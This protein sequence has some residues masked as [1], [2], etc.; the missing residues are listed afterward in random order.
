M[1]EYIPPLVTND[2]DEYESLPTSSVATHMMSGAMAGMM[3]H[4]IMYPLDSV[5]VSSTH[6]PITLRGNKCVCCYFFL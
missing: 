2:V 4:V 5:K 3:E 6:V 1:L